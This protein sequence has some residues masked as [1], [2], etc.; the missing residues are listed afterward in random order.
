[1]CARVL[2]A[3]VCACIMC[4][5]H[6]S[7][8]LCNEYV[9]NSCQDEIKNCILFLRLIVL[10]GIN[11]KTFEENKACVCVYIFLYIFLDIM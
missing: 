3:C 1:M 8:N 7:Y 9:F 11:K 4:V 5:F 10:F 6:Q 2:C